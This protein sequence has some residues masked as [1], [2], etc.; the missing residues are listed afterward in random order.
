MTIYF[1]YLKTKILKLLDS[2]VQKKRLP[3]IALY[4]CKTGGIE[5]LTPVNCSLRYPEKILKAVFLFFSPDNKRHRSLTDLHKYLDSKQIEMETD[6]ISFSQAQLLEETGIPPPPGAKGTPRRRSQKPG[7]KSSKK[8]KEHETSD[9]EMEV[10]E[11]SFDESEK[12][13]NG[14]ISHDEDEMNHE[15][16]C[17]EDNKNICDESKEQEQFEKNSNNHVLQVDVHAY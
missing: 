2:K 12:K 8:F 14:N 9:E 3:F 4:C 17:D 15:E 5:I 16:A 1:W 11:T 10:D 13:V 6:H 7:P